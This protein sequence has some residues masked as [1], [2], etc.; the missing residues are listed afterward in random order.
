MMGKKL[1]PASLRRELYHSVLE[2]HG[3]GLS[4]REIRRRIFEEFGES[5][6]K[7]TINDWV[8]R[9][10]TPYGDG[11]GRCGDGRRGYKLGS[12]REPACIIGAKLGDG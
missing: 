7:S 9:I 3:M 11:L 2:L 10:Y 1:R 6:S 8:R 12:C 4:Y 5:L